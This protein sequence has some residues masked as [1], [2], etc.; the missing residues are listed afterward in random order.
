[1]QFTKENKNRQWDYQSFGNMGTNLH[2]GQGN[3]L[4]QLNQMINT[5]AGGAEVITLQRNIWETIPK[6][7]FEEMRRLSILSG[8]EPS[9]HAPLVEPG[10]SGAGPGN[11]PFY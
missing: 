11:T 2:P 6:Q 10:L 8:V 1:M 9:I 4:Q 5:G 7:H 3:Q